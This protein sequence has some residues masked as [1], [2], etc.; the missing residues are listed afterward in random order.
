MVDATTTVLVLVRLIV[1][2][3]GLLI[4]SYSV[5]A[6]RRTRERYMRD[7]AL[8]FGVITLGVFIEGV[9]F[10]FGGGSTSPSSTSSR[11]WPSALGFSYSCI[12]SGD[13]SS[14]G[15]G[16]SRPRRGSATQPQSADRAIDCWTRLDADHA[17]MVVAERDS[18]RSLKNTSSLFVWS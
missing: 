14:V 3:L 7:A 18:S 10:E 1:L 16:S 9:L 2:G 13:S 11:R 6:Y 12:P 4:T 5:K 17:V 8:G 15:S